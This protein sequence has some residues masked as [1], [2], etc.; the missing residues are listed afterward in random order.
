VLKQQN[1]IKNPTATVQLDGA[2][3]TQFIR[4]ET[5]FMTV[6][7]LLD[8]AV[9]AFKERD[10]R[11]PDDAD[12]FFIEFGA[13][14]TV[15]VPARPYEGFFY[16]K[17]LLAR[18]RASDPEKFESVHKGTPLYFLSWLAFDQHLFESAVYFIDAAIAED[19]R[20]G[21]TEWLLL[22]A[23]QMLLLKPEQA[24]RHVV[25]LIGSQINEELQIFEERFRLSFSQDA[26][27]QRFAERMLKAGAPALV[28][29]FYAFVLEFDDRRIE[30]D[31]RVAPTPGS[32]QPLFMHLLKG[33]ILLETLLKHFYPNS[34]DKT[35]GTMFESTQFTKSL[36]FT[37]PSVRDVSMRTLLNDAALATAQSAFLTTGRLRNMLGHNLIR[38]PVPSRADYISLV[39]QE[40]AAFLYTIAHLS[41]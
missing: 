12:R 1:G 40:I 14:N 16:Y 23:S 22:P 17:S 11:D 27:L 35:L 24:A 28:A 10:L 18:L 30:S 33:G 29:A 13:G 9:L 8:L 3:R 5:S 6:N 41:R 4:S 36:G 31:L 38:N 39:R 15:D 26:F 2:L 25:G 7:Q 32:Y 34:A 21:R 20:T 19:R 37:L